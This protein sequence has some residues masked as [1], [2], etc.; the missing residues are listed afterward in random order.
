MI[1]V[2]YDGDLWLS[3]GDDKYR[4]NGHG[5]EYT[6][7]IGEIREK[8]GISGFY[9][10]DQEYDGAYGPIHE[11][12]KV[13]GDYDDPYNDQWYKRDDRYAPPPQEEAEATLA[14]LRKALTSDPIHQPGH[15]THS[16]VETIDAIEAWGLGYRLGNVVKYVSRADRKGNAIEDLRKAYQYLG[17]EIAARE[18]RAGEW[19]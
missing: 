19:S 2:D 15:Y 5:D 9:R 18:G 13:Y 6:P 10:A 12:D 7:T 4:L 11:G 17:R 1:L 14:A 16:R 3:V 8:F